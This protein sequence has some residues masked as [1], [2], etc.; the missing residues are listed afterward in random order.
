M[1]FVPNED[2]ILI[3]PHESN[4]IIGS[5]IIPDAF[6]EKPDKGIILAVGDWEMKYKPGDKV[7]YGK[8]AGTPIRV[9]GKDCLIV[10]LSDIFGGVDAF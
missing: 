3:E 1:T 6:K 4:G 8:Y 10:R 7:I 5:I 9:D 2:R